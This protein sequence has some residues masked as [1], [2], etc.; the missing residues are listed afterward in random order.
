[1]CTEEMSNLGS[2]HGSRI[3]PNLTGNLNLLPARWCNS[4]LVSSC[5]LVVLCGEENHPA[6]RLSFVV[7]RTKS[8]HRW[9]G[10]EGREFVSLLSHSVS[11]VTVKLP[12]AGVEEDG[13][14]QGIWHFFELL[15]SGPHPL[16]LS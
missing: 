1:M 16:H 4:L 10:L 8:D 6:L 13:K 11:N 9:Q 2:Y 12:K 3:C 15:I 5:P 14:W 7:N